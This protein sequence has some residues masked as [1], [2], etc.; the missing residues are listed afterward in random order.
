MDPSEIVSNSDVMVVS[1]MAIKFIE[2]RSPKALRSM[3]IEAFKRDFE[4][5]VQQ[6]VTESNRKRFR[7]VTTESYFYISEQSEAF[8]KEDFEEQPRKGRFLFVFVFHAFGVG[9]D[10][11][12]LNKNKVVARNFRPRTKKPT[13]RQMIGHED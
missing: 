10:Y 7:K 9:D 11:I 3:T 2:T 12:D 4:E 5:Y 13:E 1:E 6:R 8:S